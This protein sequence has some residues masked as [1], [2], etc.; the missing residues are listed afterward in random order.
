LAPGPAGTVSFTYRALDTSNAASGLATAT[1]TVVNNRAPTAFADGFSV[2]RC[3]FRLGA[4]KNCRTGAGFYVPVPLNLVSNDTDP[5]SQTIDVANQLPL[6]VARVRAQTSGTTTGSTTSVT[7]SSGGQVT[8]SGA[9]VTYV[10]PYN[11]AGTDVFQYRAKD[12]V[13]LESGATAAAGWA[14]VTITV[15]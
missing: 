8:I 2:P 14:T 11:F 15:Q 4:T 5:D 10:P 6:A 1:V 7:T 12:K 3:T 13:G 9:T